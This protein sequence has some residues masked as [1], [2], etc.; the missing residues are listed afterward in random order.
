[1]RNDLLALALIHSDNVSAAERPLQSTTRV[2]YICLTPLQ[3]VCLQLSSVGILDERLQ[4][5]K[6]ALRQM[7]A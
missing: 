2:A 5:L 7:R 4:T 6:Y 1:M 3:N